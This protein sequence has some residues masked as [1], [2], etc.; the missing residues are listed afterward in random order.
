MKTTQIDQGRLDALLQRAQREVDSG[1]LPSCQLAVAYDGEIVVNEVFG[2][3]SLDTRYVIFSATKA[4][5]AGAV[6][7]LLGEGALDEQMHVADLIPEF[8]T[9]GKETITLEQVM[10]HTAGFPSAPLG[11]PQWSDRQGRLQA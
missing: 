10:L 9:N 3:A 6:W 11:P 2:D 1:L 4:V 7:M 8:G 5:V